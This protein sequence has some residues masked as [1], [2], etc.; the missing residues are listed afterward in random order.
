MHILFGK[1]PDPV[2]HAKKWKQTLR[3]EIRNVERT[4]AHLDKEEKKTTKEIQQLSKQGT[5]N[6][7]AIKSLASN[8]VK[9]RRTKA[10]L[11]QG[12]AQMNSVG[13]SLQN[14]M[15]M[16]K[17]AGCME[18]S[19][20][21]MSAMNE[22]IK[23]PELQKS[24]LELGRE[25]ERAGLVEEIVA[26]GLDAMEEPGIEEEADQQVEQVISELTA[27]IFQNAKEAPT[28]KPVVAETQE[29]EAEDEKQG[30]KQLQDMR[31]RLAGL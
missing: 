17:V 2:E 26:D 11:Y 4:I 19:S 12:R 1:K 20:E 31:E 14:Q 25:M 23:I 18:S 27:Q 24:L 28:A 6:M 22:A 9:I 3:R 15:A 10:S 7:K 29:A 30:E 8:V 21:V 5:R 16:I 13:M